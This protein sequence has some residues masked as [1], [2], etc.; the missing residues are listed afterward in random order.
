M[1]PVAVHLARATWTLAAR[2]VI[3]E[4]DRGAEDLTIPVYLGDSLQLR[5][6]DSSLFGSGLVTI[7][8]ED[9]T[10]TATS[11]RRLEFPRALVKQAD[12]FDRGW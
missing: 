10:G 6:D 8:V 11:R 4:V 5:T 9:G 1:H 7:D 3:T 12:W 2:D